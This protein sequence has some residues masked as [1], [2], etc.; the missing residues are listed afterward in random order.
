VNRPACRR[1]ASAL[2]DKEYAFS[3]YLCKDCAAILDDPQ[4]GQFFDREKLITIE[5]DAII[6]ELKVMYQSGELSTH[7]FIKW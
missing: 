4:T 1:V 3:A 7:D 5:V 2:P 6:D